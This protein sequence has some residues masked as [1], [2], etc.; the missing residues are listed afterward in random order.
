M[1]K[2][3]DEPETLIEILLGLLRGCGHGMVPNA[4]IVIERNRLTSIG[5]KGR[6][7]PSRITSQPGY[8]TEQ[9]PVEDSA[10]QHRLVWQ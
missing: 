5:R 8:G 1:I 10:Y 6:R 3:I 4:E 9:A 2:G 7:G